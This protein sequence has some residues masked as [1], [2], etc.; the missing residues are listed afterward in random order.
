[1]KSHYVFKE[2]EGKI[3]SW[4]FFQSYL[5]PLHIIRG[6]KERN[7]NVISVNVMFLDIRRGMFK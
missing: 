1:M 7:G 3:G 2:I 6:N 4:Y 5:V